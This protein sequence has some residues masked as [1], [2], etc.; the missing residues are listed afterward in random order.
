MTK[1]KTP[2]T[3]PKILNEFMVYEGL[4]QINS[5]F[6]ALV[7]LEVYINSDRFSKYHAILALDCLRVT[8]IEGTENLE[9][10]CEIEEEVKP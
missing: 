7:A 6:G 9:K 2:K 8:L 4:N 10:W 1:T 3:H 5:V